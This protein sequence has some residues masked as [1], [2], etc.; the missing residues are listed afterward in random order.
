MDRIQAD[1]YAPPRRAR[2]AVPLA[3]TNFST[4]CHRN[5][6]RIPTFC[7][8]FVRKF[9]LQLSYVQT[10]SGKG[11]WTSLK[12]GDITIDRPFQHM[13]QRSNCVNRDNHLEIRF[14]IGLPARCRSIDITT[15][16]NLLFELL[17]GV[18][19]PVFFAGNSDQ[20]GLE[21]H[22]KSVEQQNAL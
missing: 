1:P 17:P 8:S 14:C 19:M 22:V 7:D 18:P 16:A 9:V 21:H 2:A 10:T 11:G 13:L 12:G 5:Q 6:I 3:T 15:A 4:T 20:Q